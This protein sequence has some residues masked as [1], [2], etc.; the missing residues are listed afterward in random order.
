MERYDEARFR[1]AVD[2]ALRSIRT[3]LDN[4]R[5]PRYPQDVPHQ[6][7]DKYVLAEF[8]TRTATAAILQCLGSIG[9]SSEGLGQ[10]VGWAR[11]RSVTLRFQARESCTFVR[12]ETRQV[13]SA[14]Q[15][16]TEKRTFFG[17]TEKTTEKIVTTVKEYL[18][19][20]DFAYELVAYRG[21]ETDKALSLHARSGH[22]ELK[23]GAKTTPRPEKVV[24]SPLDASVTWLLGQVDPQQRA[25]F[26]IDRTSAA[27]HTPRR[28]PEITAALAALGELSAWCGQV[29]AY[30]LHE[31]FAVQPDHGRDLSVI[32]ADHVFVPVVPVFEA[33]GHV[34]GVPDEAGVG[35]RSAAYAG[36]F[37][38]EQQRT[39][40]A[41]C[42]VLAQVFPRDESLVTV[43]DAV[44]LVTLR[45]AADIA[46]RFA[47]GV[48]H[49]EAML[50][51]QLLAA[52]GR[53]LS[54]A[55]FS[56][57]MD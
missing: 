22:I 5:N 21:N 39:L 48:E 37:L 17:G 25:S 51:E 11:D 26:T 55:D 30:F 9:L 10:L 54:P 57:Y 31:L 29:H 4:A 6:Y 41:H 1:V 53:E 38:A 32:H 56:A 16:V 46:Q 50:R 44:L 27:C 12:E 23:T 34:P 40:A 36:P 2:G 52:I 13:E 20:F 35:E 47:D 42:A 28:N 3:I 14:S 7:D 45:H 15:H 49:I 19:R 8:L 18:W 43:T 33:A 24:R